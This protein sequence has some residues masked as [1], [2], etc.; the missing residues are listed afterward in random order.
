MSAHSRAACSCGSISPSSGLAFP[1]S[2]GYTWIVPH[3]VSMGFPVPGRTYPWSTLT[4][5]YITAQEW[6]KEEKQHAG[7]GRHWHSPAL[8][9][10]QQRQGEAPLG[11]REVLPSPVMGHGTEIHWK[12]MTQEPQG[13]TRTRELVFLPSSSFTASQLLPSC[14]STPAAGPGPGR[15]AGMGHCHICREE[16]QGVTWGWLSPVAPH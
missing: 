8:W 1:T 5:S 16:R 3:D 10:H 13:Q 11:R 7:R 14:C 4:Q 9:G 2:Y 12:V 15:A 6:H